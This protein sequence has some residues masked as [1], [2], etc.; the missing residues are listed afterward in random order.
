MIYRQLFTSGLTTMDLD[1]PEI[2][3]KVN[4]SNLAA[5]REVEELLKHIGVPKVQAARR[6]AAIT[7]ATPRRAGS[8]G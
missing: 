5:R 1:E 2:G 7:D 3:I 6:A 4:K 8:S